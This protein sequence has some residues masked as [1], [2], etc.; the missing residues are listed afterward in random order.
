[1]RRETIDW[2]GLG[3]RAT[4]DGER[5]EVRGGRGWGGDCRRRSEAGGVWE[6]EREREGGECGPEDDGDLGF[7][8]ETREHCWFWR[9]RER[10]GTLEFWVG[11]GSGVG[12]G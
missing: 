1:M 2:W 8:V 11:F 12:L 5:R 3:A 6:G 9:E 4:D 7:G 10:G